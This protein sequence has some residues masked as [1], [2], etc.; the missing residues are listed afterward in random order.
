M[1]K[2]EIKA[3]TGIDQSAGAHNVNMNVAYDAANCNTEHGVLSPAKGYQPV[4]PSL[5][6]P[7][8]TLCSFYRRNI[9]A[10]EDRRVL[11]AATATT[12]YAILEG[13][14]AWT[15]LM[16]G[17]QSGEWSYVTYETLKN[18]Q[19]VDVLIL[20]NPLDGVVVVYGD[21]LTAEA[22]SDLPKFAVL[23]R[24]AERI[25]GIGV[26]GEP[27]NLYYSKP[28]NPFD[29]G[30]EFDPVDGT[31]PLP[32]SS[33]GVI[34]WPT[35]DGDKFVAIKRF[36]NN[37]LAFKERSAF[38]VRGLT[39]GEFA[40]VEAYGSDGVMAPET[41]VTD[42]PAAYY[43]SE[44]GFGAYDG[45]NA[46][47]LDND[48]LYNVFSM[49]GASAPQLACAVVSRHV[50]YLSLPVKME[51][52]EVTIGGVTSIH[53]VEPTRNNLLVEYDTRRRTYMIRTG[54]QADAM[55]NHG[56]RL[57]FTSGDNPYQVFEI[58]G[59]AYNDEP[60]PVKWESAWQDLGAKNAV[61]SGF[62]VHITGFQSEAEQQI[63][64]GI[65]TERKKKTKDILL[66]PGYK[67]TKFK[68]NN[69]GRRFRFFIEADSTVNWQLAGGV[70]IEMEID[71][72]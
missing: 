62:V 43:L 70:Q 22:K 31:T 17:L 39:A 52:E 36:S 45:F 58:T 4:Y 34:Q 24:H 63:T 57:L 28:F 71:E 13:G 65:E 6:A 12:L 40:V 18:D 38:Y 1:A 66:S 67:K 59:T 16:T 8:V 11:V 5:P 46:Q 47:L 68:L 21:D 72:D 51:T 20:S 44:G 27:D 69:I 53:W 30:Y 14:S 49:V 60:I 41:I 25:W 61:K 32:E 29:W 2:V 15:T 64:L 48:R 37:L 42:G 35:W 50:V 56:G 7:I 3:F 10:E 19:T 33:G 26:P 23:E 9:E 54:I 55:H